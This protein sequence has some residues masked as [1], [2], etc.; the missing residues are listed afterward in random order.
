MK[1]CRVEVS[2]VFRYYINDPR[3]IHL[4]QDILEEPDSIIF[5][6]NNIIISVSIEKS[7]YIIDDI[8]FIMNKSSKTT[9][10]DQYIFE[11]ELGLDELNDKDLLF[12]IETDYKSYNCILVG[13]YVNDKILE[14]K[15]KRE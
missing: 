10:G 5:Q 15:F 14:I 11:Y 9:I 7:K 13:I 1:L 2:K 3:R 8:R 6:D 12:K 4:I